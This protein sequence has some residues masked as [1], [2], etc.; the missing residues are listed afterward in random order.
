[1]S[2]A[3][4]AMGGDRAPGVIVQGVLEAVSEGGMDITLVRDRQAIFKELSSNRPHIDVHH[5]NEMVLMD[6]SPYAM[7][8]GSSAKAIKNAV[9]MAATYIKKYSGTSFLA[10]GRISGQ[11]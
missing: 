8:G 9:K 6:E 4:D 5:C 3:V 10:F 11:T 1:M 7:A 2:I